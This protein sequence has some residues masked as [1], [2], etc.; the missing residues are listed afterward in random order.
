[1]GLS[2]FNKFGFSSGPDYT[3]ISLL[4][5]SEDPLSMLFAEVFRHLQWRIHMAL[6]LWRPRIHSAV[7]P[8]PASQGVVGAQPVSE[9]MRV[10]SR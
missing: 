1:M 2:D 9:P 7:P 4:R 5:Q 6:R 8:N 3:R 10:M